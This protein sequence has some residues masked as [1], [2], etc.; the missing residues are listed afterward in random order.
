MKHVISALFIITGL[1]NFAP[2]TGVLSAD[3]LASA[4]G[5]ATPE[6]DLLI[7]L[8]HRALL[9]GIVG[10]LLLV[11]AF[12]RP[13]RPVATIAGMI[14]MIGFIALVL[15]DSGHGDR[16]QRIMLIDVGAVIALALAAFLH[17]R[18]SASR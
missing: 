14:S 13:L 15:M 2:I 5:I 1:I 18:Q 12:R 11:A 7:L 17:P 10:G 6:G 4:Y 8:R 3:I 9:F 16:L